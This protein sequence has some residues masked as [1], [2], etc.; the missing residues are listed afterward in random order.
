MKKKVEDLIEDAINEAGDN[1]NI[2][3]REK[4]ITYI[5]RQ[6]NSAGR[7]S[8]MDAS[9]SWYCFWGINSLR[10]LNYDI[11]EDLATRIINF[12]KLCENETGGYGGAPG[13]LSHL[14]PTY[15]SVMA[16]ISIG[17]KEAF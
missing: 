8:K 7:F 6:L 14:A 11:P 1:V 17:T 10:M 12:L 5:L 3:E 13:Q 9:R 4:H 15:A 16:L 2:L